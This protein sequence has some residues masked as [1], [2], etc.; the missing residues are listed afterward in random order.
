M[1]ET[2]SIP[3]PDGPIPVFLAL[4]A[5]EGPAPA[6]IMF[7]DA[8]GIREELRQFARRVASAGFVCVLPDMFYR[9]G[10]LRFDL[11]RRDDRM[12]AVIGAAMASLDHDRVAADCGA[13]LDFL[14]GDDRVAVGPRGVV[15][16]CMSGQYVLAA[17]SRF[18]ER[19][20]AVAAFHGVRMVTDEPASPHLGAAAIE[21]EMYLGFASDD[22]LVPDNVI[23]TLRDTFARHAIDHRIETHPGTRHGFSF[24]EREAYVEEA[25]EACWE[26]MLDLFS[27]RLARP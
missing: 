15:G 23:P 1:E 16:Y 27:R 9:L 14:D 10:T 11:S 18:P 2:L 8:P 25:A 12:S 22:P 20:A 24:P 4:P 5:G 6:V 17:A 26:G 7:M 19:I 21:A 13:I 3:A